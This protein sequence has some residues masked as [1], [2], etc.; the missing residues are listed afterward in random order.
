M[1]L[2]FFPGSVVGVMTVLP[3]VCAGLA[4]AFGASV[5]RLDSTTSRIAI[6]L[7]AAVCAAGPVHAFASLPTVTIP[8]LVTGCVVSAALVVVELL[9]VG[10]LLRNMASGIRPVMLMPLAAVP[11]TA[12]SL[13]GR[14][15]A[16]EQALITPYALIAGAVAAALF[17]TV[18]A[19]AVRILFDPVIRAEEANI[20]KEKLAELKWSAYLAISAMYVGALISCVASLV[21]TTPADKWLA[22]S[23]GN[24]RTLVLLA[25]VL[26]VLVAACRFVAP[27]FNAVAPMACLVWTAVMAAQ[28]A[29]GYGNW[30]QA[31]LS[32]MAALITGLFVLEG[33]VGNIG[34][35]HDMGVNRRV[36]VTAVSSA[37]AAGGTAAWATGPA[38][39]SASRI[40]SVP[41]AL[42]ALIVNATAIMSLPWLAGRAI[43]GARPA[44]LYRPGTPTAGVLQDCFIVT[45]LS[46]SVAWIPNLFMAHIADTASWW[47]TVFP[48]FALLSKAYVYIMM[49]NIGHVHREHSRVTSLATL[50]ARPVTEGERQALEALAGHVERQN[51]IALIAL[52]P[53]PFLVLINE[54]TGFEEHGFRQIATVGFPLVS[55]M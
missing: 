9:V 35:L 48:F 41:F 36:L 53:L 49:N 32:V 52:L 33:V 27:S 51:R 45:V 23:S 5:L 6:P 4:G 43:P 7:C 20:S 1:S 37:L 25:L 39:W 34:P 44:Q 2:L 12:F 47:T 50:E 24:F 40:T 22:G 10:S 30:K 28:L 15:F 13:A 11:V 3:A 31:S 21:G 46:T 38:L 18:C 14:Y 42:A 29:D 16:Q 54:I 55:N 17:L 19:R 26:V 8:G